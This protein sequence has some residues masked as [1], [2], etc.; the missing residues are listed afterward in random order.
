MVLY[1]LRPGYLAD[2]E[3]PTARAVFR[4]FRDTKEEAVSVLLLSI[5]D[6]RATKGP[7]TTKDSRAQHEWVVFRLIKEYFKKS[8]EKKR[9]RLINGDILIKK[10][11]LGPSPLIGEILSEVEELQAIGKIKNKVGALKAARRIIKN[12]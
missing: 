7:L 8:K 1:H 9:P 6:Q 11:K 3:N 2:N 4:Y 5:A 12:K 10:F